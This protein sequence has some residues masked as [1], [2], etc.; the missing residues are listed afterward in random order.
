M[1]TYWQADIYW[2]MILALS[3]PSPPLANQKHLQNRNGWTYEEKRI[4][5]AMALNISSLERSN[6]A[7]SVSDL[8]RE[9]IVNG[10]ITPGTHLIEAEIAKQL[11]VSRGPLR[12]AFRILE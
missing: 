8:L 12:E 9:S 5:T 6:L 7:E 1:S 10:Q 11:N 2:D 4:R 3:I